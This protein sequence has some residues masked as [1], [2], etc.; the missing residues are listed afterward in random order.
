MEENKKPKQENLLQLIQSELKAPKDQRNNFGN[1]TYRSAESILEAV[2]PI[3]AKYEVALLSGDEIAVYED[4]VYLKTTVALIK[5]TEN[6]ASAVGFAREPETK[7]G[8]DEAQITGSSASYSLKRA[9]GNLLCI[10]D[11]SLD[12]DKTNKHGKNSPVTKKV[13]TNNNELI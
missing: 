3:L 1:Y 11:S 4:R 12:P 2:K 13:A 9:L 5:G 10:S 6:L 7:R 8:M